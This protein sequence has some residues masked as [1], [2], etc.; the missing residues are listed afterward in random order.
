[1]AKPGKPVRMSNDEAQAF[2]DE[3]RSRGVYSHAEFK[4]LLYAYWIR[5]GE[6]MEYVASRVSVT[7]SSFEHYINYEAPASPQRYIPETILDNYIEFLHSEGVLN[8]DEAD[9]I[10][11]VARDGGFLSRR[12]GFDQENGH[13]RRSRS[14][15]SHGTRDS[16]SDPSE[17]DGDRRVPRGGAKRFSALNGIEFSASFPA[18]NVTDF[19]A[20]AA[21]PA[22][23]ARAAREFGNHAAVEVV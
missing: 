23:I 13:S 20:I 7:T 2:I 16:E 14:G 21:L 9:W 17:R 6:K 3:A 12:S 22:P 10:R 8:S 18:E 19:L 1:M 15:R 11:D 4:K 5:S